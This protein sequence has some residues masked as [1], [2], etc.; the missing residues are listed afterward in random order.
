MGVEFEDLF[1]RVKKAA[2]LQGKPKWAEGAIILRDTIARLVEEEKLP[3]TMPRLWDSRLTRTYPRGG[4]TQEMAEVAN[5]VGATLGDYIGTW[6]LERLKR[7]SPN[8]S[9]WSPRVPKSWA[10]SLAGLNYAQ[11]TAIHTALFYANIGREPITIGD[12]RRLSVEEL[13]ASTELG[14][15]QATFLKMAFARPPQTD[16]N[17]GMST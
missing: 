17:P 8:S 15:K 14:P 3:K 12:I 5:K 11:S 6:E 10:E 1:Q 7:T 16:P 9:D 4:L 13:R 2:V